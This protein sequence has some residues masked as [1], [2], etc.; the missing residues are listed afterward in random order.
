MQK[1]RV[2][3][4]GQEDPLEKKMATYSSI[5]A[6]EIPCTEEPERLQSMG[7]QRVRHDWVAKQQT[8][9]LSSLWTSQV[10]QLVK[11]PPAMQETWVWSLG[12]ED[13]L[14]EE[15]AAQSSI[16]AGII[17]WMIPLPFLPLDSWSMNFCYGRNRTIYWILIQSICDFLENLSPQLWK[18]LPL[19]CYSN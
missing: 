16:L 14:E 12:W 3:S 15:M 10:A 2:R 4:L 6:W 9:N 19:S 17:T 5:L 13:P 8:T 7:S 1:M 18:E 11:N